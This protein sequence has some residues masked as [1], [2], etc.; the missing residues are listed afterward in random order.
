MSKRKRTLHVKLL[1]GKTLELPIERL[2][3][4]QSIQPFGKLCANV[5]VK[6]EVSFEDIGKW[7][8]E[9]AR[10]HFRI[11]GE[12]E[13]GFKFDSEDPGDPCCQVSVSNHPISEISVNF[14]GVFGDTEKDMIVVRDIA[15][16][17][18]LLNAGFTIQDLEVGED[19]VT[20][21]M[22]AELSKDV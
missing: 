10:S 6:V 9:Q 11:P 7:M 22:F 14:F 21:Y 13:M 16:Q 5:C 19:S 20:Y 15:G 4:K 17:E 1:G 12:K 2:E 8:M 18:Q 3:E